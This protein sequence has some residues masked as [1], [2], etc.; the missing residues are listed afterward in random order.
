[1]DISEQLLELSAKAGAEMAEVVKSVKSD[2]IGS[3]NAFQQ[4]RPMR[5]DPEHLTGTK[6]GM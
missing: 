2:H 3:Q 6:R 5:Q 4:F 1:M